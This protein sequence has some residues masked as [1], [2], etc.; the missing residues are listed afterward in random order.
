MKN[1]T[2]LQLIT[3]KAKD[4]K[5]IWKKGLWKESDIKENEDVLEEAFIFCN[6][7][8]KEIGLPGYTWAKFNEAYDYRNIFCDEWK[9]AKNEFINVVYGWW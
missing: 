3:E 7:I 9:I 5:P 4:F 6:E 1:K 2:Y 8:R